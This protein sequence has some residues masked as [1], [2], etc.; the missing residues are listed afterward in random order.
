MEKLKKEP[1]HYRPGSFD[2][3]D[4]ISASDAKIK[5]FTIIGNINLGNIMRFI[6]QNYLKCRNLLKKSKFFLQ[7]HGVMSYIIKEVKRFT[8]TDTE[9]KG[10][11]KGGYG[12]E[13]H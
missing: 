13:K 8:K 9:D 4:K 1:G 10:R 12:H 5:R 6:R 2:D 11:K 7:L 3:I